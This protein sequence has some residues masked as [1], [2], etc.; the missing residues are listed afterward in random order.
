MLKTKSNCELH[1]SSKTKV[2]LIV[3]KAEAENER[4]LLEV[5]HLM[6][7]GNAL[8][9]EEGA[10][11]E[12]LSHL[13]N[14]FE[15]RYYQPEDVPPHL[16]L[17]SLMEENGLE[18][19]DLVPLFGSRSRVSEAVNGKRRLSKAQIKALSERFGVP[20]DLFL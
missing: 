3:I 15:A 4:L 19:K 7:R 20:S 17:Q 12:L 10:L 2:Q 8:S 1:E 16:V 5:E 11:L 13:I 18:Q 14:D 6:A 9:L